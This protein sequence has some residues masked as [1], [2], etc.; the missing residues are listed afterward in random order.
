MKIYKKDKYLAPYKD[1]IERR[2]ALVLHKKRQMAGD[3]RLSDVV[4]NHLYYVLHRDSRGW[5]FREWAP[6]ATRIWLIGDFNGWKREERY[7]FSPTGGGNWELVVP[8]E[9]ISHGTLYRWYVE[10]P[11][12][13]GERLPSYATRCVQDEH[14]KIFSA[15]VWVP[16]NPYKW[17]RK[18]R[19][20]VTNPLIY[21]THIGMSSEEEKVAG[22]SEFRRNVLPRIAAGGYNTIQIM[23][24]Q[25]HPY[26]GSFGYQVSN[27]CAQQQIRNSRGVQGACG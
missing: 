3:G 7:A 16:K 13:G 8:S 12:G 21:E 22:F 17:K 23:A 20:K 24:L 14:T 25:E 5:V 1:I 19:H 6:N 9:I 26:Y 27:F 11:G 2:N 10:W 15:Q 18:F 4:N